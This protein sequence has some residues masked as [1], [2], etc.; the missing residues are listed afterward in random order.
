MIP[1][2]LNPT[3]LNLPP[4]EACPI[5]VITGRELR[6]DRFALR[7]QSEFPGLVVAWLQVAPPPPTSQEEKDSAGAL[8]KTYAKFRS[9]FRSKLRSKSYSWAS[10][11]ARFLASKI[12]RRRAVAGVQALGWDIPAGRRRREVE[13]SANAQRDAEHRLFGDE[14]ERLKKAAYID[15]RLIH[16]PNAPETVQFIKSLNPYF[17]VTLGGAIYHR[18][19]RDC[20]RGLALNQHDGWCPEY[21]GT[22]TTSWACIIATCRKLP[23]PFTY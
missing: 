18:E 21:R 13:S 6:H 16:D 10:E 14:I 23:I 5:V 20:A 4:A 2:E 8:R 12:G 9:K 1:A 3:M 19:L 7:L 17:I 22:E 15:P 11:G